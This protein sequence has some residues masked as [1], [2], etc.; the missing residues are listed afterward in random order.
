[1]AAPLPPAPRPALP[2]VLGLAPAA[3][4]AP[5]LALPAVPGAVG[6]VAAANCW[7][8]VEDAGGRRKGDIICM[9]PV[10]LPPG[11]V[12]LGSKA[13]IPDVG[14]G[15]EGCLVVKVPHGDAPRYK[16]DDLRVLPVKFDLQGVRRRD[17]GDAVASM[18]DGV[19]QG[20]GACN[21][22]GPRLH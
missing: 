12:V 17:F 2:G 18:V 10:S 1:M 7:V 14:G 8:A 13:L 22:M 15:L 11:Y 3:V 9:D 4:A 16:L 20:G 21:W 6:A 19:P 5:A